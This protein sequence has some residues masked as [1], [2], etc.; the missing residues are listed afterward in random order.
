MNMGVA[1]NFTPEEIL[2][3]NSFGEGK[4]AAFAWP[5][6]LT[7]S[8]KKTPC[9]SF[10]VLWIV[11]LYGCFYLLSAVSWNSFFEQRLHFIICIFCTRRNIRHFKMK[12]LY[13]ISVFFFGSYGR[14]SE[15]KDEDRNFSSCV[16]SWFVFI[17]CHEKHHLNIKLWVFY[18]NLRI[19]RERYHACC[20]M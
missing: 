6:C 5:I 9:A 3:Y 11:I 10:Y 18:L 12:K 8:N 20:M 19:G 13:L 7:M 4:S 17:S 2:W 1:D 16:R 14:Y 15:K